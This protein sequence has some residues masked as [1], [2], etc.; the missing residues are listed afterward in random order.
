[1]LALT[2]G[3]LVI[4]FIVTLTYPMTD[5]VVDTFGMDVACNMDDDCEIVIPPNGESYYNSRK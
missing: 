3:K 1:M 4:S 5:D 2:F